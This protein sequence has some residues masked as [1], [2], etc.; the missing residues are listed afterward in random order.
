MKFYGTIKLVLFLDSLHS[1][2]TMEAFKVCF[3]KAIFMVLL[4]FYPHT[5][6]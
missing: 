3:F 5:R 6:Y 2:G 1:A 4:L